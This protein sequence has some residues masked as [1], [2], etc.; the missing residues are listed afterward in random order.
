MN[1]E[2]LKI[3]IEDL[4]QVIFKQKTDFEM[5]RWE[6]SKKDL[7]FLK[8]LQG[9][10]KNWKDKNDLTER[11]YAFKMVEDWIDE[12]EGGSKCSITGW[13]IYAALSLKKTIVEQIKLL[14]NQLENLRI[15]ASIFN[16]GVSGLLMSF[17]FIFICS[18][19][20]VFV[21]KI[22]HF[23]KPIVSYNCR[24]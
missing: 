2:K 22:R 14:L 19:F 10:M 24:K 8:E 15:T 1:N 18:K 5:Q 11:D 9:R 4:K 17:P 7:E 21:F 6:Q 12:L 13:G 23:A 16:C 20:K 3:E